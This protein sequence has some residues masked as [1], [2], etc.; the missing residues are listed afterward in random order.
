MKKEQ[1]IDELMKRRPRE[2]HIAHKDNTAAAKS[3]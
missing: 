2:E 1:G 3:L